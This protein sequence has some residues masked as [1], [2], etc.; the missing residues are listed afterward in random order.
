MIVA[1]GDPR[2]M[3]PTYDGGDHLHPNDQ[4]H[5]RLANTVPLSQVQ[6]WQTCV[7]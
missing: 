7:S 2:V 6:G 3:A 5:A 4:G 1:G